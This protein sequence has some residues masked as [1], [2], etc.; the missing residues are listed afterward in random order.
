MVIFVSPTG[1]PERPSC[2]F[3]V[4][5]FGLGLPVSLSLPSA[6]PGPNG[7]WVSCSDP[8]LCLFLLDHFQACGSASV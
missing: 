6:A 5:A 8:S 1:G 4:L 2:F 3:S 7:G